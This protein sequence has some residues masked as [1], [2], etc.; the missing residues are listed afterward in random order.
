M[1]KNAIAQIGFA[2]PRETVNV[3]APTVAEKSLQRRA[4]QNQRG[5][6]DQRPLGVSGPERRIDTALD[7]PRQRDTGEV[8]G[9]EREDAE[10]EEPAV[11]INE[12]LDPMVIAKNRPVLFFYAARSPSAIL[13]LW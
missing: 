4:E 5:I 8:G 9:D 2:A 11:A 1:G 13:I 6:F 10:N 3:D 12:K 7:Q